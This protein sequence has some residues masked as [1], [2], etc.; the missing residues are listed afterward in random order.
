MASSDVPTIFISHSAK[1]SAAKAVLEALRAGLEEAGFAVWLDSERL[2]RSPGVVWRQEIAKALALCRGA[3]VLVS[4]SALTSEWVRKETAILVHR[5][6]I[7]R[8]FGVVPVLTA[9]VKPEDLKTAAWEPLALAELQA[10]VIEPTMVPSRAI[11]ALRPLLK[12]HDPDSPERRLENH[13]VHLLKDFHASTLD[14]AAHKL[15]LTLT[16]WDFDSDRPTAYARRLLEVGIER[17]VE[18]LHRIADADPDIA[19]DVFTTVAPHGW[20]PAEAR[21][22]VRE[23]A[24]RPAGERGVA[25]NAAG[26]ATCDMYVRAGF[27]S[28]EARAVEGAFGERAE[29]DIVDR[30]RAAL[31]A[32]L[33]VPEAPD[34]DI[35]EAIRGEESTLPF[36]VLPPE[37]RQSDVTELRRRWPHIPLMVRCSGETQEDF[38][39]RALEHVTYLRPPVDPDLESMVVRLSLHSVRS[40]ERRPRRGRR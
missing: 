38:G 10:T 18:S 24:A 19:C 5:H 2:E 7:A 16:D 4:P 1:E 33:G 17:Q 35:D 3:V 14:S 22:A 34:E 6:D 27:F 26:M 32:W 39:R 23:S 29:Q 40:F 21:T 13:L 20:I 25:L 9:G 28:W 37:T 36:L 12:R 11:D 15:D 31:L 30:A 8:S